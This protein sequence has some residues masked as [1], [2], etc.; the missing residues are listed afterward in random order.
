MTALAAL[1]RAELERLLGRMAELCEVAER[2]KSPGTFG[3]T[4]PAGAASPGQTYCQPRGNR[5]VSADVL[6]RLARNVSGPAHDIWVEPASGP[7]EDP[8]RET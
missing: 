2:M 3:R 8:R 5:A 7:H 1:S 4:G 6:A